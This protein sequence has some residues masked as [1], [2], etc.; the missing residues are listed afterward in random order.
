MIYNDSS[1]QR[2]NSLFA[3]E[4]LIG[5][6]LHYYLK[7]IV[8]PDNQDAPPAWF[9]LCTEIFDHKPPSFQDSRNIVV[10]TQAIY[11]RQY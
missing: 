7:L 5:Y 2:Q 11:I 10:S 1:R 3:G 9:E 8:C 6:H 4:I